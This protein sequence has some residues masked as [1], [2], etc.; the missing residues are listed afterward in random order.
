MPWLPKSSNNAT[1]CSGHA[2]ASVQPR[3]CGARLDS[4]IISQTNPS[5]QASLSED[6][7][8]QG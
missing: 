5:D 4:H 7:L 2:G 8:E 3:N 6:G 1:S